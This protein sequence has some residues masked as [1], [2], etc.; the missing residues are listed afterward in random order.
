MAHFLHSRYIPC[1][2]LALPYY[3]N[4]GLIAIAKNVTIQMTFIVRVSTS[5]VSF[6]HPA[7]VISTVSPFVNLEQRSRI[8]GLGGHKA[9]L[10]VESCHPL[11]KY[12]TTC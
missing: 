6:S 1:S 11:L 3:T 10:K 9:L 12:D 7:P 2:L 8:T 4:P 5:T